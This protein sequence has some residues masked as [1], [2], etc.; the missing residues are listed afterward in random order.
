MAFAAAFF[1]Y[2]TINILIHSG[3]RFP[4]YPLALFN[5]PAESHFKH[6]LSH[7]RANFA[8]MTPIWDT[9]FG[10]KA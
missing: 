9:V 2:S 8:S 3:I 1:V 4:S 7:P 6:H 5:G 10:T